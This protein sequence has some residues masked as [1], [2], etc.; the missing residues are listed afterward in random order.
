M[1]ASMVLEKMDGIA[2]HRLFKRIRVIE[3]RR[4]FDV[5]SRSKF[6]NIAKKRIDMTVRRE[7]C[8]AETRDPCWV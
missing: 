2:R 4:I 1:L 3:S 5:G 8:R 6:F 7:S